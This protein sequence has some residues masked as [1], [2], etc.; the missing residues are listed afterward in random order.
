MTDLRPPHRRPATGVALFVLVLLAGHPA[1]ACADEPATADS[2]A[3]RGSSL[4]PLPFYMYSPE[5]RSGGGVVITYLH[6][7]PDAT[8][9]DKPS[10]YSA[11]VIFTQRRQFSLGLGMD[12]F[13]ETERNQIAAG[14]AF[15]I[16]PDT[17][18][19]LGNGTEENDGEDYTPRTVAAFLGW[20][21]EVVEDLRVGPHAGWTFQEM[22]ETEEGGL[23]DLAAV[24]GSDGGTLV[25]LGFGA[26]LDRRD[27]IV[28]PRAGSLAEL[29]FATAQPAYGSDFAFT[30]WTLDLRRYVSLSSSQVVAV[31]GLA[32]AMRG[33]PPFPSLA[34]LGGD[35]IMR[36]FYA[37][38]F[39]ERN[40]YVLQAEYRLGFWRRMGLTVFGDVGDVAHDIPD[41]RVDE[42]RSA[43]GFGLRFLL[44][45]SEGVTLRA[46]LGHGDD[47]SG[48]L[49]LSMLEAF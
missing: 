23:L 9:E 29:D 35:R 7:R 20:R 24:A 41:F 36:G 46:D 13:D 31:R 37:G 45:R 28:Y 27:N 18:H 40:L 44:S 2:T 12:R 30:R 48:G 1:P 16:F 43:W 17:F 8:A 25:E 21:R 10:T 34:G 15:S 47:G 19:G 39:R 3:I 26:T 38:R 33:G 6:R 22:T 42:V 32:T 14:A 4:I 11:N 5:T 49:Y